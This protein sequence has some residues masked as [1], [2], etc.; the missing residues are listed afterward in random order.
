MIIQEYINIRIHQPSGFYQFKMYA[1]IKK[2]Y[3]FQLVAF[4]IYVTIKTIFCFSWLN[5][6]LPRGFNSLKFYIL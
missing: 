2:A 5:E 6:R 3:L 1:M 4:K